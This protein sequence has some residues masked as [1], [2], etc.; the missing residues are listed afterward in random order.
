M[1]KVKIA[2]RKKITIK[3]MQNKKTKERQKIK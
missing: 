3:K 1:L 2:K